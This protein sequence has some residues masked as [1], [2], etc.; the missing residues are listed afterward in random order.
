MLRDL[1]QKTWRLGIS[2]PIFKKGHIVGMARRLLGL[3]GFALYACDQ[4]SFEL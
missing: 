2:H 1:E 4:R 3:C